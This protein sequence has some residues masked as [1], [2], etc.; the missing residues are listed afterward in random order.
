MN[1]DGKLVKN[2]LVR[3]NHLRNCVLCH[4]PSL[5]DADPIRGAVPTPGEPLPQAYYN[6]HKGSFVR[7]DI[8]YLKQD[9]S[10]M[11]QVENATPWPSLQRFDY[12]VRVR[13]L[14]PE[15]VAAEQARRAEIPSGEAVA[16]TS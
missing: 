13:E 11:H 14:T 16:E 2:E 12:L 5:S 15:E 9:F 4:A 8:V 3:I 1:H 6:S 7:A 10:A